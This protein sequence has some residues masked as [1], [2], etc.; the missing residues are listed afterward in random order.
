[1]DWSN[2]RRVNRF[3]PHA[4]DAEGHG[5]DSHSAAAL[6]SA[7]SENNP[8]AE[9]VAVTVG[10][11]LSKGPKNWGEGKLVRQERK[12][13]GRSRRFT[14]MSVEHVRK[15]KNT[16]NVTFTKSNKSRC[17]ET[18]AW[19]TDVHIVVGG[20]T[21]SC[22]SGT[23]PRHSPVRFT[24]FQFGWHVWY[25][26]GWCVCVCVWCVCFLFCARKMKNQK[27]WR[28]ATEMYDKLMCCSCF[29]Y[30][31]WSFIEMA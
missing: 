9:T 28:Y 22:V 25:L 13:D 4:S 18:K 14:G 23:G 11:P 29:T 10:T 12:W 2:P 26:R 8:N 21:Q 16:K 17:I 27:W 30:D 5:P 20:S 19:H 24:S 31:S 15:F 1:M 6:A 3:I 7:A